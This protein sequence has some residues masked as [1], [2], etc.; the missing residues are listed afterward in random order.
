MRK[1][2]SK[3]AKR[4]PAKKIRVKAKGA[5]TRKNATS[6]SQKKDAKIARKSRFPLFPRSV[7]P[8]EVGDPAHAQGHR[9]LK[10]KF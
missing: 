1:S 6:L 5:K 7:N 8:N 3:P 9:H 10:I 2:V 4:K